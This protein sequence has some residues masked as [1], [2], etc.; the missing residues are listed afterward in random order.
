MPC[1]AHPEP[2]EYY[3]GLFWPGVEDVIVL[4]ARSASKHGVRRAA[5][6]VL[7]H[8]KGFLDGVAT[9]VAFVVCG[10][11]EGDVLVGI[12]QVDRDADL[13]MAALFV[14]DG[15]E[16]SGVSWHDA[17]VAGFG[18]GGDPPGA[19]GTGELAA[20]VVEFAVSCPPPQRPVGLGAVRPPTVAETEQIG[21]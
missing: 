17:G 6:F 7:D 12:E 20:A 13:A 3:Q 10:S 5:A 16:R 11:A 2:L 14:F 15:Q 21:T 19:L 8:G 1:W 18:V 4:F 9:S